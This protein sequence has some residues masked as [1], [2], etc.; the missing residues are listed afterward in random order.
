MRTFPRREEGNRV[1]RPE[2]G[3]ESEA[4][5][6][7][8][9]PQPIFWKVESGMWKVV[10]ILNY[11]RPSTLHLPDSGG[12]KGEKKGDLGGRQEP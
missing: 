5:E 12:F 7:I 3:G 2:G 9:P 8:L 4:I 1:R 11:F 6:H 10:N